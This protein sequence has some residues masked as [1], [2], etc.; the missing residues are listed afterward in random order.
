MPSN[1]PTLFPEDATYFAMLDDLKSRIRSAQLK[2]TLAVKRE[3]IL[4]YWQICCDILERQQKQGWGSKGIERLA[5][6]LKREFPNI[7][8]FSRSNLLYMRA[9]A[10]AYP[11]EQFGLFLATEKFW[12][13]RL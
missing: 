1:P 7:K 10:E 8:G 3:L 13:L 2:A 6:D 4:L 5:K 12:S 11:D 9:F